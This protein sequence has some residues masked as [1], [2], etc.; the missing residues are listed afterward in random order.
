MKNIK[1]FMMKKNFITGFVALQRFNFFSKTSFFPNPGFLRYK[2]SNQ[3]LKIV[4]LK[5]VLR[6]FKMKKNCII[7][8][9]LILMRHYHLKTVLNSEPNAI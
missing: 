3:P 5:I 7:D 6:W 2:V 1:I 9:D 4:S 8:R